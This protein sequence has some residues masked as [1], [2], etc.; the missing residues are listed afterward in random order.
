[1]KGWRQQTGVPEADLVMRNVFDSLFGREGGAT[2]S[3][4]SRGRPETLRRKTLAAN[5][6]I[7]IATSMVSLP[8]GVMLLTQG[9]LM[10]FVIATIGLCAGFLTLALH[11]RGQE[12]LS[13]SIE[14]SGLSFARAV[15]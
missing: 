11:R 7:I 5:S 3:D 9:A 2:Q 14:L 4:S 12:P 8:A 1:M 6:R 15:K 13:H 10:P